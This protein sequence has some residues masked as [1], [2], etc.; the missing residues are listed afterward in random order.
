MTAGQ[1]T[2]HKSEGRAHVGNLCIMFA[3]ILYGSSHTIVLTRVTHIPSKYA[4]YPW[5]RWVM[6]LCSLFFFFLV[7][8]HITLSHNMIK[9]STNPTLSGFGKNFDIMIYMHLISSLTLLNA[10]V[11]SDKRQ[12]GDTKLLK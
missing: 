1:M 10:K 11:C 9:L 3:C 2:S 12:C 5:D 8:E 6:C 7:S 4:V